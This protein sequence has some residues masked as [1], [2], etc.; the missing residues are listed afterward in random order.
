[1]HTFHDYFKAAV[2]YD[3]LNAASDSCFFL[4]KCFISL[5]LRTLFFLQANYN[6]LIIDSFSVLVGIL[7]LNPCVNCF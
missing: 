6:K 2:T 4:V 3:V 1:M 5:I 7:W